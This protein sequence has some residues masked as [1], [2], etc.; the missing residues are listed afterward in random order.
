MRGG[1]AAPVGLA[2]NPLAATRSS[3]ID[4]TND[5]AVRERLMRLTEA[6]VGGQGP[7]A[8]HAFM[9]TVFNRA[10]ARGQSLTEAMND[11]GYYPAVSL[12]GKAPSDRD[13]YGKA[14]DNVLSGSNVSNYATGNA[15]GRV[16]FAGGP[17]TYAPGTGERFG[18]EGP[19]LGWA[20]SIGY[21]Q[22]Q[23]G[24][25]PND[26]SSDIVTGPRRVASVASAPSSGSGVGNLGLNGNL[27][28]VDYLKLLK[29]FPVFQSGLPVGPQIGDI[30]HLLPVDNN[31]F[32]RSAG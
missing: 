8:T 7:A 11:S 2:S 22:S 16:M 29:L 27:D 1:E 17:Q 14:L 25:T 3:F 12:R 24:V 26:V 18:R 31:P 23:S 20:N 32:L 13:M 9:E 21:A 6:E 5:P 30:A 4:E 15:S 10:A 19:D 28:L